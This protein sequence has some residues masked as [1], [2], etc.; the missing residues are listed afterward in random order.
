MGGPRR[1]LCCSI[2]IRI[3]CRRSPKSVSIEVKKADR[4]H[5]RA[6]KM[7]TPGF[8]HAKNSSVR[9][10]YATFSPSLLKLLIWISNI[11]MKHL[12][13]PHHVKRIMLINKSFPKLW[14]HI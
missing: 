3:H 10:V 9:I 13:I 4:F 8:L 11:V 1:P 12:P 7:L 14:L 2:Q 6:K 5:I